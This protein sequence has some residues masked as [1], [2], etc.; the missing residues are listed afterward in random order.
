MS[1]RC[2]VCDFSPSMPSLYHEGLVTSG[3]PV[4]NNL[5]YRKSEGDYICA[6][7]E[8]EIKSIRQRK[9]YNES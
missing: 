9:K 1:H 8:A 6:H 3:T 5:K 7:C 2:S 4:K